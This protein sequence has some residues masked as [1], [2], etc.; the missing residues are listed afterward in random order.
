[1]ISVKCRTSH[2]PN[3]V[4]ILHF[5]F[6]HFYNPWGNTRDPRDPRH[7]LQF[8]TRNLIGLNRKLKKL[9]NLRNCLF[10]LH[11]CCIIYCI[12]KHYF[13][14]PTWQAISVKKISFVDSIFYFKLSSKE[15]ISDRTHSNPQRLPNMWLTQPLPLLCQTVR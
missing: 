3:L 13:S 8:G 12:I 2:W 11:M 10:Y 5:S 9:S 15:Y 4:K 7:S 6:Y 14:V 1:M